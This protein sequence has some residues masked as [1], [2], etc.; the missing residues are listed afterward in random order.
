MTHTC[1]WPRCGKEIAPRLWGC[2]RHWFRLPFALRRR[3]SGT[4]RPGQE[5]DKRP[6]PEYIEAAKAVQAWITRTTVAIAPNVSGD[7]GGTANTTPPGEAQTARRV[8]REGQANGSLR[9]AGAI[10]APQPQARVAET[11]DAGDLKSP[12]GAS[13]HAG[14]SPA[15]GTQ[16]HPAAFRIVDDL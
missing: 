7:P 8:P 12:E 16:L 13:A 6:S 4:Y 3:I 11:V 9:A 1:H 2:S 5:I 15:P 10:P 14:S